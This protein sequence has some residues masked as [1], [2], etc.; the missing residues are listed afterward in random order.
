[1]KQNRFDIPWYRLMEEEKGGSEGG[2]PN[3]AGGPDDSGDAGEGKPAPEGGDEIG[4]GG[5]QKPKEGEGSLITNAGKEG[6]EGEGDGE[7]G[8]DEG[9]PKAAG[10]PDSYED[11]QV[12]EG[13]EFKPE[14]L[15]DFQDFAK[16]Q[17]FTQGQ[18]QV[19]IDY[20]AQA[21]KQYQ[22][23]QATQWSDARK[24]WRETTKA[25]EEIGGPQMDKKMANVGKALAKFGTPELNQVL[26]TMGIGDHPELIRF[27]YRVGA[28]VSEGDLVQGKDS[29]G[30]KDAANVLYPNMA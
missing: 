25:D 16:E 28:M 22:E 9:K 11:F 7:G 12:P 13:Y 5:E 19:L 29:G 10:A 21:L 1:M 18:A 30:Q 8:D 6:K 24:E 23:L 3:G 15:K 14:V 17:D 4:E 26:D 20:H 2:G 27:F